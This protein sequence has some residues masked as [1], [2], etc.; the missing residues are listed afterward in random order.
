[1]V[2]LEVERYVIE[3]VTYRVESTRVKNRLRRLV[4][5]LLL[6][7]A[8]LLSHDGET[9]YS[10]ALQY[11]AEYAVKSDSAFR[12]HFHQSWWIICRN[13]AKTQPPP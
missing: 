8:L 9:F 1:M 11:S 13:K 6:L 5:G 7:R 2:S 4:F 3:C 10:V 12:Q